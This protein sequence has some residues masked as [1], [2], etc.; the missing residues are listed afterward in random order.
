MN[1]NLVPGDNDNYRTVLTYFTN[2]EEFS[3]RTFPEK[4]FREPAIEETDVL[5]ANAAG[6]D[7]ERDRYGDGQRDWE[8][9]TETLNADLACE[10]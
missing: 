4:I 8:C 6:S 5:E 10:L 3:R 9:K 2:L 7:Q 1:I